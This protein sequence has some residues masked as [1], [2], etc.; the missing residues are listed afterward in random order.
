[1]IEVVATQRSAPAAVATAV[2]ALAATGFTA[3]ACKDRPGHLVDTLV[4]PHL[5]DAVRMADDGYASADD[6][7][8]AMRLGCG[9]PDGPFHMLA[10]IGADNLRSGLLHLAAATHRSSYAPPPLLDELAAYGALG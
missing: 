6:I 1:V 7:D 8:T 3:I 10:A 2:A 9:Y 4:L 5:G